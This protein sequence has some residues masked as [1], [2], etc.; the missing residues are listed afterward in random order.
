MSPER[1]EIGRICREVVGDSTLLGGHP[2]RR[3][4]TPLPDGN[5]KFRNLDG[6]MDQHL[7]YRR[8]IWL[9]ATALLFAAV[10]GC[11]HRSGKATVAQNDALAATSPRRGSDLTIEEIRDNGLVARFYSSA[12]RTPRTTILMLAGSGG[13]FPDDAAARDLA[14]SGYRVLGL[15]YVRNWQGQPAELTRTRLIDVPLEYIFT[16]LDWLR[17]RR[18]VRRD[19]IAIMGESR[20]AE[21]AL[22]V[23]SYRHD[24]A[25][26]IAFSPSEL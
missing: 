19:G 26:V 1:S 6:V 23:G 17:A 9:F 2:R 11:A 5:P 20:G 18:E 8:E 10:S 21:L 12:E 14:M 3:N 7:M 25:G 24:V 16:A 4:A 13:G 22:L 15:A